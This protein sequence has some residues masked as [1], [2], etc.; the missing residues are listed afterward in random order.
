MLFVT[1]LSLKPTA[2]PTQ[3]L[4]RRMEWKQPEGMKP[5]A[6]YWLQTNTPRV[7]SIDEADNIAPI[8]AATMPWMDVFDITVVP[9]ISAEEGLKLASQMMP[10]T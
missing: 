9:A 2:T 8:M 6:E 7:I 1:L 5:I 3:A 10:K 4:Q